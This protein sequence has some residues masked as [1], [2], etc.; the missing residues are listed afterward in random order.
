MSNVVKLLFVIIFLPI[1]FMLSSC[2]EI[3]EAETQNLSPT[4]YRGKV[5][6]KSLGC[7][8]IIVCLDDGSYVLVDDYFNDCQEG[9]MIEGRL[10]KQGYDDAFNV[11]REQF[12][13]IYVEKLDFSREIAI[14]EWQKACRDDEL[15]KDRGVVCLK[16]S[17]CDYIIV[18]LD[19]NKYSI[20]EDYDNSSQEGDVLIGR[21]Q[22][23]GLDYVYNITRNDKFK[24]NVESVEF[25][26]SRATETWEKECADSEPSL[27]R[28]TVCLKVFDCD[29]M[30]VCL[31]NGNYSIVEDREDV[32][33]EGDV[34][35]GEFENNGFDDAY[36]VTRNRNIRIDVKDSDSSEENAR[37][38]W[39]EECD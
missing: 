24:I 12:V 13:K 29:Y 16:N 20:V 18:C 10:K 11:T 3:I 8:Y 35:I 39:E 1:Y 26:E 38:T 27:E 2:T 31:D 7:D 6:F 25:L 22:N 28:G 5:C 32:C 36:N 19:D 21:F 30:I 37:E 9:D 17:I 34:L 33:R 14:E 23:Y 15:Y 4:E